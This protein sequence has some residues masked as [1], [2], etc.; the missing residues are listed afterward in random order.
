MIPNEFYFS[1]F[2]TFP[3]I[4]FVGVPMY[5]IG[6]LCVGNLQ[7][8]Q[9]ILTLV[10]HNG[11]DFIIYITGTLEIVAVSWVYGV[12]RFCDDIK[13]MINKDT[14]IYWKICWAFFMPVGLL[15]L[16]VYFFVKGTQ[17]THEGVPFPTVALGKISADG[18]I[19]KI[20]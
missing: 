6:F 19:K 1:H 13:F 3:F 15:A 5:L 12:N 18:W 7:G 14:A 10:N 11:V 8:G 20:F 17:L 9:F 16:L 4:F 2:Q